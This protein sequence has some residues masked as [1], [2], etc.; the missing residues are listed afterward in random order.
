M[1][2]LVLT[3]NYPRFPGDPAG[4]YV[5]RLAEAGAGEG[6]QF[7][8]IA[9]HTR[10]V[11]ETEDTAGVGVR[12][13]RYAP[14]SLERVGYRGYAEP[15]LAHRAL[16]LALLPGYL[17]GFRRAARRAI[18]DFSPALV[19][20]HWW[21]PGGWV[22]ASL[23]RPFVVTSHGS[24]VRLFDRGSWWRRAG[25]KVLTRAGAVTAASRFLANDL[26]QHA[27]PFP[28]A[29]EITPMP[30][31][32][33]LFERGRTTPKAIPPRILYAGNLVPSKGV[34]VLLRAFALLR[35]QRL[36]CRLRILG[37]GP[38][39]HDLRHLAETLGIA[40]DVD[41]SAFVPQTQMPAEYG[42]SA[43]SVLASRGQ[44]EGLG[45]ALVEALVAGCAIVATPAGGI[46]EVVQ[47]GETGL[48]ARDGDA[49]DLAAK[50]A[51]LLHDA[52][53]RDRLTDTGR[54][55][56]ADR[57]SPASAARRFLAL[58]DTVAHRH[59]SR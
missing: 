45:L 4:A 18:K 21:F 14:T 56:V 51:R 47:D 40:A 59:A 15:G 57:Y 25:R 58:Y 19:H 33:S 23:G 2:V 27:G 7:C 49:A 32:V 50:I 53:L 31:D 6:N 44:S 35:E 28:R 42:A 22:A 10:G 39:E 13:F 48:L 54:H 37:E 16:T 29:V 46:P 11:P 38:A 30:I 43:V 8:V 55:R 24:D 20:A 26:E 52:P 9:P 12:R 17:A 34:D 41:W 36:S 3:H 5:A 1:R